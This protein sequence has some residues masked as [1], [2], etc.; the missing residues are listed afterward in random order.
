MW[1]IRLHL[2]KNGRLGKK[3]FRWIS[4]VSGSVSTHKIML[5][6]LVC[7]LP[8]PRLF[9]KAAEVS[10]QIQWDFQLFWGTS[11]HICYLNWIRTQTKNEVCLY[12]QGSHVSSKLWLTGMKHSSWNPLDFPPPTVTVWNAV[13][14][15]PPLS[16]PKL[17]L[18][19]SLVKDCVGK[20]EHY[21]R[22][23]SWLESQFT[24]L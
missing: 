7:C 12:H 16:S 23:V 8:Q 10:L 20:K 3:L 4:S 15:I 22:A 21:T 1:C 17:P 11:P 19:G 9:N 14:Q 6:V 24:E 2:K 18:Q 5:Y 13:W